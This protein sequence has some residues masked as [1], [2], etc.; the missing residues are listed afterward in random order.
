MIFYIY[1][2]IVDKMKVDIIFYIL[3]IID[4]NIIFNS[5]NKNIMYDFIYNKM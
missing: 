2:F 1:D 3:F 4:K 5:V